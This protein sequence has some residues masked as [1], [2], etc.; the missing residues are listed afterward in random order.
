MIIYHTLN[1]IHRQNWRNDIN[2]VY[3]LMIINK[4]MCYNPTVSLTTAIIEWTLAI[5]LPFKYSKTRTRYF[6]SVFL[7][8][9]GFYQFTEFMFCKTNQA[10]L[11]M[12]LGFIAYTLL[13]AIGL[14]T[15]LYYFKIKWNLFWIYIIPILYIIGAVAATNF[16]LESKCH[17]IFVTAR[18]IFSSVDSPLAS[19]RFGIYTAYYFS[20]ILAACIIAIRA[21]LKETNYKKQK[22]LL[23]F[24]TAVFLMSFPTFIL[25]IIFPTLN[26]QFPSILCHF[27][28]LLALTVFIGAR[29][30][31]ELHIKK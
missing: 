28:L 2:I 23:A 11:W 4:I 12:R 22:V 7:F 17:D 18:N 9:L 15:T 8:F 13:P 14:H 31:H 3:T 25:V 16:V 29:W 6:T 26:I 30:D 27:A 1:D 19:I 5:I 10:D 21:Y 20:F 24:P